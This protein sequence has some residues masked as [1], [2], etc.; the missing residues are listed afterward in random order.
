MLDRQA[1]YLICGAALCHAASLAGAADLD[2]G[3]RI[4]VEGGELPACAICHKLAH[5]GSTGEIGPDLDALD[6]EFE[7]IMDAVTNGVGVMPAFGEVLSDQEI[8]AV[9]AY[10]AEVAGN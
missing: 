9:S 4:F 3:K 6:P 2:E 5:A 7:R 8:E 1:R 10:V